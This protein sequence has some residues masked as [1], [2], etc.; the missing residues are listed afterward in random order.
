MTPIIAEK[1]KVIRD[2]RWF[3]SLIPFIEAVGVAGSV[4]SGDALIDSDID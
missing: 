1:I 2:R 3:F 4:A